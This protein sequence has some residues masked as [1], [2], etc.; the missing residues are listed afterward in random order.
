MKDKNIIK[1]NHINGSVEEKSEFERLFNLDLLSVINGGCKKTKKIYKTN[2]KILSNIIEIKDKEVFTSLNKLYNILPTKKEEMIHYT[3]KL[4]LVNIYLQ[5]ID[6]FNNILIQ[7][8][9][10]QH[11]KSF[12]YLEPSRYFQIDKQPNYP[13][14]V[15]YGGNKTLKQKIKKIKKKSCKKKV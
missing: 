5:D 11:L 8:S 2:N 1:L 14:G 3:N 9:K 6:K 13:V 4:Y 7:K 10:I 12:Q 15:A